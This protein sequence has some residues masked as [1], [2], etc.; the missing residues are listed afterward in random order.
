MRLLS[1]ALPIFRWGRTYSRATLL[2][3][4]LA[5]LI[6]T[7]LM[8]PQSLAYALLAGL[9]AEV[10]LYASMVPLVLYALLGSSNGLSV[11]PVAIIA[12]MTATAIQ[13]IAGQ[14]AWSHLE[15]AVALALLSGLMLIVMGWLRLGF[16]ANFLSH[17]V[18]SGFITAS[19]FIIAA[20][21]TKHLFGIEVTGGNL[22]KIGVSLYHQIPS[23]HWP[24]AAL[25]VGALLLLLILRLRLGSLL[26]WLGFPQG[27]ASLL[28]KIGPLAVIIVASMLVV[29]FNLD[30]RGVA[31]LGNIPSALPQLSWPPLD[32]LLWSQLLGSAALI[33]LVGFV[34]SVSIGQT[35]A[36]KRRESIQPNQELLALG[37]A[38]I[39][40]A[41]SG[42]MPVSGGFSRTVVN[43]EAGAQTPAAGI[44]AAIGML[45][46]TLFLTPYLAMLP[47]AVLSAIIIVAVL[48][49]VDLAFFRQTWRYSKTDFLTLLIT[50]IST[51]AVSVEAGISLGIAVSISF[52]LYRTSQPHVAVVGQ[53][54]GTEH[55]R[56]VKRHNVI[57]SKHVLSLR[58]DASLY[59]ANARYLENS[60]LTA[61]AQQPEV[62]DLVLVC[63]AVNGIDAS[64]LESLES[65]MER[66]ASAGIRLHL[67]EVKG[68][69]MDR[70]QNTEFLQQLTGKVF[71]TQFQA[72]QALAPEVAHQAGG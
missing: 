43:I 49:L 41:V 69:V 62:K 30:T 33:S 34:E 70:L 32:P 65:I 35:I 64:A 53:V 36:A 44:Y 61:V 60:I 15:V 68:P 23:I 72:M 18:I 63:T 19:C 20:S 8:V 55:F 9:P 46:A 48:S 21:Q 29:I 26:I 3:D 28:S 24:T 56:N 6:V 50:V 45:L 13:S 71:L 4:L 25:G 52:Y 17:S 37:T 66:L 59:F 67:S 40:A 58:I 2:S 38:N 57:T 47:K 7:L 1:S 54:P 22:W 27:I 31:T 12:L 51:M 5:A 16:I 39:G 42:A 14:G 10:G 11:G